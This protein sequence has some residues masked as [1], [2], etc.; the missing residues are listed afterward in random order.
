MQKCCVTA[1]PANDDVKKVSEAFR[2]YKPEGQR[3]RM[4]SLMIGLFAYA[5]LIPEPAKRAA[6]VKQKRE[7]A[8]SGGRASGHGQNSGAGR[9]G[10]K[11]VT[12]EVRAKWTYL[13]A[14]QGC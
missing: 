13:P 12:G 7:P 10:G 14:S 5:G 9:R 11:V 4:V 2:G 8:K 3:S 6:P 1:D